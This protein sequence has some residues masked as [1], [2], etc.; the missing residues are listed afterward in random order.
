M[1]RVRMSPG[2]PGIEART[3]ICCPLKQFDSDFRS[4]IENLAK[5]FPAFYTIL[6]YQNV[7]PTKKLLSTGCSSPG[8]RPS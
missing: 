4:T 5:T 3:A 6:P 7:I 8:R 1:E 2:I